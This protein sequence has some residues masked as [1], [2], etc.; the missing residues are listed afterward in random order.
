MEKITLEKR[1]TFCIQCMILSIV[2]NAIGTPVF[3]FV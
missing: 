2:T 1:I 3:R